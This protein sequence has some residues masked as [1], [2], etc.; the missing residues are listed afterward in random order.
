M[1][2]SLE[3]EL[4]LET[5]IIHEKK[6]V[7]LDGVLACIFSQTDF[8]G[9]HAFKTT[10]V[11]SLQYS[12]T[13]ERHQYGAWHA[14]FDAALVYGDYSKRRLEYFCPSFV[15]GHPRIS[16]QGRHFSAMAKAGAGKMTLLYAPTWGGLSNFDEFLK[17]VETLKHSFNVLVRPHHNSL[18]REIEKVGA[19][20]L[21]VGVGVRDNSASQIEASDIVISDYSGFIFDAIY[22]GKPVILFRK[23]Y[24][25]LLGKENLTSE[26]IEV[27][28]E[29]FIGPVA[30][31]GEE[32]VE[33]LSNSPLSL[34]STYKEKNNYLKN[35]CFSFI[36]D[37]AEKV[38]TIAR[39][40]GKSE[41][42]E[43]RTDQQKWLKAYLGKT[44]SKPARKKESLRDRAMGSSAKKASLL[45]RCKT[46]LANKIK[47]NRNLYV[48]T[49]IM[50]AALSRGSAKSD[51]INRLDVVGEVGI[52]G[53]LH[54]VFRKRN[55]EVSDKLIKRMLWKKGNVL[56]RGYSERLIKKLAVEQVDT[57]ANLRLAAVGGRRERV[58]QVYNR[59]IDKLSSDDTEKVIDGFRDLV[60]LR[61]LKS[62]V[63]IFLR[64]KVLGAASGRRA[65]K[66]LN[67]AL[68][69]TSPLKDVCEMACRNEL[70]PFEEMEAIGSG[71]NLIHFFVPPH[72]YAAWDSSGLRARNWD[73]VRSIYSRLFE[74]LRKS[75][76]LRLIPRHQYFLN[77]CPE[78]SD[79]ALTF[80]TKS[81][82]KGNWHIKD[83]GLGGKVSIDP[84]GYYGSSV[85]SSLTDFRAVN[86]GGWPDYDRGIK[87]LT[88][89]Y[90]TE[91][92]DKYKGSSGIGPCASD[93][94]FVPLQSTRGL[95]EC[96]IPVENLIN[97]MA[98]LFG[99]IGVP[100][101]FKKHP[102][103][104]DPLIDAALSKA[105]MREGVSH[106]DSDTWSL[107]KNARAVV[108]INSGVGLQ[109]VAAG[110]NVVTLGPSDVD[111]IAWKASMKDIKEVVT[112]AVN[113][114]VEQ[115]DY[116]KFAN[117]YMERYLVDVDNEKSVRERVELAARISFRANDKDQV[118]SEFISFLN[119]PADAFETSGD[120]KNGFSRVLC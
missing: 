41:L 107:V 75:D 119:D 24:T 47:E 105:V 77:V 109:A 45:T 44:S 86:I 35:E 116:N 99:E 98:E 71:G 115:S 61:D 21:D 18:S 67:E 83:L 23:N 69:R 108:T 113:V 39:Q 28:R 87:V 85:L 65:V 118:V 7:S 70:L 32:L 8:F 3:S 31:S 15:V 81:G 92:G 11:F 9:A 58:L 13:K 16:L 111:A 103:C 36:E 6:I 46:F 22:C 80:F 94:V 48:S 37:P 120:D 102:L 38:I 42:Y 43:L 88:S 110:V 2:D 72:F 91:G 25:S 26:S 117:F 74:S 84:V 57:V 95:E 76:T 50:R 106:S 30:R 93:Y 104:K 97:S 73:A 12:M 68:E 59:C 66:Q 19:I 55:H 34:L 100:V 79:P 96:F 27:S 33:L 82:G 89:F 60:K 56:N 63:D 62:A 90:E 114:D 78:M 29:S 112:Q 1:I 4:I 52:A 14:G 49:C 53:S 5:L 64:N 51:S 10:K 54:W 17:V 40:F 20:P 101:V